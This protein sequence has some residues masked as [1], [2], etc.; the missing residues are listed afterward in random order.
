MEIK[1]Q[2]RTGKGTICAEILAAMV[3]FSVMTSCSSMIKTESI[4]AKA[5]KTVAVDGD[6]IDWREPM[7]YDEKSDLLVGVKN[8]NEYL[9]VCIKTAN[10]A[11]IRRLMTSGISLWFNNQGS[12]DQTFGLNFPM[13]SMNQARPIPGL[14]QTDS[15]KF[16]R[17]KGCDMR[18]PQP[19]MGDEEMRPPDM[20][21]MPQ[22]EMR[23][24]QPGMAGGEMR[25]QRPEFPDSAKSRKEVKDNTPHGIPVVSD[26][27]PDKDR[28]PSPPER[29]DPL[30]NANMYIEKN[31]NQIGISR[32]DLESKYRVKTCIKQKDRFLIYEIAIPLEKSEYFDLST[33]K[34]EHVGLGITS[35]EI[36]RQVRP[37]RPDGSDEPQGGHK[38]GGL[39]GGNRGG[40][41]GGGM[42]GGNR[43]G[44][45]GGQRGGG[46]P[47][48]HEGMPQQMTKENTDA[49]EIW[50]NVELSR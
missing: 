5:P 23:P 37:E 2:R 34:G 36:K 40:G 18:P 45:M 16:P 9:Y 22:G 31:K 17:P 32:A 30:K 8:D 27:G 35:P 20:G 47:G 38:M 15:A 13:G 26:R 46:A 11:T 3:L 33:A 50:Y 49:I 6:D 42:P 4:S 24:P 28:M 39:P 19:G 25:P 41:M 43:G 29:P 10:E 21:A 48:G 1:S 12:A 7:L 14:A 44:G